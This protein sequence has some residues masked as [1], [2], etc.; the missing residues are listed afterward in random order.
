MRRARGWV[1]GFWCAVYHHNDQRL[2]V[3]AGNSGWSRCGR[4]MEGSGRGA[5]I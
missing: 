1:Q 3:A 5:N 2:K 4:I